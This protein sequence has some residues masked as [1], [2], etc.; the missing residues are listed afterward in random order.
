MRR[1][2]EGKERLHQQGN[3]RIRRKVRHHTSKNK[4]P[5]LLSKMKNSCQE[6]QDKKDGKMKEFILK[7]SL[8]PSY[9][10]YGMTETKSLS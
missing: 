5:V 10:L 6:N 8:E 2:A 9:A 3:L 1:V 7:M 4:K